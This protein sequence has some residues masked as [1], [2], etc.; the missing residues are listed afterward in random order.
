[1]NTLTKCTKCNGQGIVKV[2]AQK[3]VDLPFQ[4]DICE[5]CHGDGEVDWIHRIVGKGSLT[6]EQKYKIWKEFDKCI[7]FRGIGRKIKK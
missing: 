5:F 6:W 4:L 2:E 7:E 1:M 3:E